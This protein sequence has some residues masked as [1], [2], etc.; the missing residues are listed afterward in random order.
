MKYVF[1]KDFKDFLS[2]LNRNDVDYLL[3]GGYS[4]ILHG[5][6]RN[7]G[8]LDIWVKKSKENYHRLSNAFLEFRMP[9]FDMTE[10]AFLD[11]PDFDV[12]T[13]GRPPVAIDLMT[14]VKG[15]DFDEA[16]QNSEMREAGELQIRVISLDDLLK[17]KKASGRPKDLDDIS[18]L[19]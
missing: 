13:F 11:N 10:V 8:D 17:A 12:F 2:A 5:Y 6:A 4:V 3:V 16:F 18:H 1:N 7:T 14:A 19:S 15:L 9:L